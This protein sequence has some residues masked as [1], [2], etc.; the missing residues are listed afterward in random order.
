[1]QWFI[2]I[3]TVQEA[4]P[5]PPPPPALP[6]W[7][8]QAWDDSF[9]RMVINMQGRLKEKQCRYTVKLS[10]QAILFHVQRSS[11]LSYQSAHSRSGFIFKSCHLHDPTL[12][13]FCALSCEFWAPSA[14]SSPTC[15]CTQ[16]GLLIYCP[17]LFTCGETYSKGS[18]KEGQGSPL[19]P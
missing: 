7:V 6:P 5:T 9:D 12:Q 14:V 1:M 15:V 3:P 19:W 4:P 13:Y 17:L 8:S 16:V 2:A 18:E 11:S 10:F